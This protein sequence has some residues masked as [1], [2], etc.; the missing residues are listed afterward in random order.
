MNYI[1]VNIQQYTEGNIS[2]IEGQ[3]TR[4]FP[5]MSAFPSGCDFTD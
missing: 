3:M 1:Y 4:S 5:E 2:V